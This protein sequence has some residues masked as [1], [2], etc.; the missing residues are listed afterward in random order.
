[1]L[2]KT[3]AFASHGGSPPHIPLPDPVLAHSETCACRQPAF[4]LASKQQTKDFTTPPHP[5]APSSS[6]TPCLNKTYSIFLGNDETISHQRQEKN[7]PSAKRL[8]GKPIKLFPCQDRK[9]RL[10]IQALHPWRKSLL[11]R[12]RERREVQA[13]KRR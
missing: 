5:S 4:L 11:C 8:L 3:P 6:R 9:K 2:K 10:D 12:A 1:M 13:E 7:S